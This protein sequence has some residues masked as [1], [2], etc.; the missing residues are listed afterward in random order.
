MKKRKSI[1][2]KIKQSIFDDLMNKF[3]E[4]KNIILIHENY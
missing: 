3:Y 1:N 4:S 2:Y